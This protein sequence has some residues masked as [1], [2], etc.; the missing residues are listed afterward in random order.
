MHL[1]HRLVLAL[2]L[3]LAITMP[4][5]AQ[6]LPL[7]AEGL[8][9]R[10]DAVL[11]LAGNCGYQVTHYDLSLDWDPAAGAIAASATLT[12]SVERDLAAFTLDFSGFTIT[13]LTVDGVP[14][15]YSR[16]GQ[17]L[18]V[19]PA[20]PLLGG[21]TATVTVAYHGLPSNH[22]VSF[23]ATGWLPTSNGSVVIGEPDGAREWFPAND[24]PSDKA[25]F[26]F[27]I[28]VPEPYRVAANGLPEPPVDHGDRVT[29][30]FV[31][32][33]PMAPYLATIAI[34]LFRE[35]HL[36][37][38]DGLPIINYFDAG[39][40]E[41]AE[42]VF[43]RLPAIIDV[44]SRAFGAYPFE[45]AGAIVLNASFGFALET[46]TRPVY[47]LLAV[48]PRVA[49]HETAHQWFGNFISPATWEDIWLNE[50][51]ASYAELVWLEATT[52]SAAVHRQVEAWYRDSLRSQNLDP[53]GIIRSPDT[54][55]S[56]SVYDRGA[57]TL[58][59]LEA[60]LGDE[61]F[62]QVLRAYVG[63]FGGGNATIADF[64]AVAETVAGEPLGEFFGRWLYETRLPDIP[65]L[66][67]YNP[68]ALVA[69]EAR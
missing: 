41:T 3:L 32:R 36:T 46:Q 37:G 48:D 67:L 63:R 62:A 17:E 52:G 39:V 42:A 69:S 12:L 27:H 26:S 20:S 24:H 43:G 6:L 5:Q 30:T 15:G 51:F 2:L 4:A 9:D 18:M 68:G 55:F 49:A 50:G 58:V 47:S 23:L 28:T 34:G 1:R 11:P 33:D 40:P 53:P 31:A 54:L 59:A 13:S 35:Q 57:L 7:A 45:T 8:C 21:V 61:A 38:P 25:T 14:A 19:M 44:L 22:P 60:R 64:V 16:T 66:G 65:E 29:Y 10:P 56:P